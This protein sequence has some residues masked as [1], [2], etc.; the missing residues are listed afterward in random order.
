[1]FI[2]VVTVLVT[3]LLRRKYKE[4]EILEHSCRMSLHGTDMEKCVDAQTM[5]TKLL[6]NCEFLNCRRLFSFIV[7]RNLMNYENAF[8][9]ITFG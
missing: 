9:N 3:P 5:Y 7:E 8:I 6:E 1:M 2:R 4:V